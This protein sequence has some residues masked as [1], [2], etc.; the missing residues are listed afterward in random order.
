MVV[1]VETMVFTMVKAAVIGYVALDDSEWTGSGMRIMVRTCGPHYCL[2]CVCRRV[3]CL[4]VCGGLRSRNS[5]TSAVF[6]LG[7]EV[8]PDSEL[9]P[10][11]SVVLNKPGESVISL[12]GSLRQKRHLSSSVQRCI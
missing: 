9:M 8:V 1:E 5:L 11:T 10:S 6:Q 4:F 7:D 12:M 2:F 3:N